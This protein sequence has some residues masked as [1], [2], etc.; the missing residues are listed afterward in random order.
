MHKRKSEIKFL[1]NSS[2][3]FLRTE[4]ECYLYSLISYLEFSTS[5]LKNLEINAVFL[6]SGR[7]DQLID[8]SIYLS[9]LFIFC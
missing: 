4:N 1:T 6:R 8:P 5:H 3:G 2:D 7:I 9:Y